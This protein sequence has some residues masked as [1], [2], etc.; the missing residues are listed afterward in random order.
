MKLTASV[1]T[2]EHPFSCNE[3]AGCEPHRSHDDLS[4]E[5]DVISVRIFD[6]KDKRV[7]SIHIHQDGS[8]KKVTR[9]R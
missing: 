8:S 3:Q 2:E 5:K 9:R 1:C 4:G 7:A 6:E